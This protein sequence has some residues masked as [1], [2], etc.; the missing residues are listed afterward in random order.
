[1]SQDNI[2]CH[3]RPSDAYRRSFGLLH[4]QGL[5]VPIGR[6]LDDALAIGALATLIGETIKQ[7]RTAD[8]RVDTRD[9]AHAIMA[10]MGMSG[11]HS[12]SVKQMIDDSTNVTAFAR[13]LTEAIE[14]QQDAGTGDL[15]MKNVAAHV[16][17]EM[18]RHQR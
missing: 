10:R 11:N 17:A 18:R 2:R 13:L 12:V 6:A 4:V 9:V 16:L 7:Q 14:M 3:Y 8:G 1:M 15:D 5:G